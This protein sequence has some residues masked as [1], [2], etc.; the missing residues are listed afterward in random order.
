MN[1][2]VL[3]FVDSL[4]RCGVATLFGLDAWRRLSELL[5]PRYQVLARYAELWSRKGLHAELAAAIPWTLFVLGI[6]GA[7]LLL[8]PRRAGVGALLVLLAAGL[9][10][11]SIWGFYWEPRRKL[12][13]FLGAALVAVTQALLRR[14]RTAPPRGAVPFRL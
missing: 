14:E 12:G 1:R 4:L 5:D 11:A 9:E 7:L 2:S 10:L 13:F 6:L 3:R 8:W